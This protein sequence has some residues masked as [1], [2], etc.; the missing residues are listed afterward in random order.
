MQLFGI[1]NDTYFG[2]QTPILS[3]KNPLFGHLKCK[4][5]I[6]EIG[7]INRLGAFVAFGNYSMNI[8]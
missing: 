6:Y 1:L 5:L 2:I 7:N 4:K 8:D 3:V